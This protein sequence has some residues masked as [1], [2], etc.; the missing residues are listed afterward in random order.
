MYVFGWYVSCAAWK[1]ESQQKMETPQYLILIWEEPR[2]PDF[3]T[4]ALVGWGK[5]L[6]SFSATSH[7]MQF[8]GHTLPQATTMSLLYICESVSVS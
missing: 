4:A 8:T 3:I 5:Y 2:E 7:M 1:S 6:C